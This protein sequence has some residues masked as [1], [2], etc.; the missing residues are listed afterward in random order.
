MG[1]G[2]GQQH[3]WRLRIVKLVLLET[4]VYSIAV[5]DAY[6]KAFNVRSVS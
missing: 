3:N 5:I 6:A 1:Q 4:R 2:G